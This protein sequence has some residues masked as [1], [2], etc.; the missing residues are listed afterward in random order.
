MDSSATTPS[1]VQTSLA[2][3]LWNRHHWTLLM[4]LRTTLCVAHPSC[5]RKT[6]STTRTQ[7]FH[8]QMQLLSLW[9]C[10]IVHQDVCSSTAMMNMVFPW[11]S[12]ASISASSP[13][14]T[15]WVLSSFSSLKWQLTTQSHHSLTMKTLFVVL[16][17]LFCQSVYYSLYFFLFLS[18][19]HSFFYSFSFVLLFF[20]EQI[21]S[22]SD[23][24]EQMGTFI[25]IFCWEEHWLLLHMMQSETEKENA[26]LKQT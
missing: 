10:H 18:F 15:R 24:W 25:S 11:L 5:V 16:I 8:H 2:T 7:Q 9:C 3:S 21:V 4:T 13:S 1:S 23:L 20:H 17:T 22:D 12:S 6:S 26:L 19:S 14:T